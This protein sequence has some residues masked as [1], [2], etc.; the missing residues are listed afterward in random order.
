MQEDKIVKRIPTNLV[1]KTII[2]SSAEYESNREYTDEDANIYEKY[3]QA[4]TNVSIDINGDIEKIKA[5]EETV[6]KNEEER[7]K[8]EQERIEKEK[9]RI[10]NES[11]RIINEN[12]RIE[13]ENNRSNAEETRQANESER[14]ANESARKLAEESREKITTEAVNNIKDLSESYNALAEEKETELNNIAEDVKDMATEFDKNATEQTNTFNSNAE[15]KTSD[16]NTNA[17]TKHTEYDNNAT[18]KLEEYNA[19]VNEF[20]EKAENY[21]K[22]IED[23]EQEVSELSDNNLWA[24]T[25]QATELTVD[26]VAKYSK[27]KLSLFGNTYQDKTKMTYKCNG[28][29]S[30]D[31]YFSYNSVNYKFTMPDIV[32]DDIMIFDTTT[33]AFTVNDTEITTEVVDDVTELTQITLNSAPNPDYPQPIQVV[34]GENTI[35][36]QGKNLFNKDKGIIKN[37]QIDYTN[38]NIKYSKGDFYQEDYIT[39]KPNTKYTISSVSKSW[40]RVIE[41]DSNKNYI[42]GNGFHASVITTTNTTKYVRIT[43]ST[44]YIDTLQ[45]EEGSSATEYIAYYN[46][47]YK[48]NL[49][50]IELC[51][52]G[53]NQDFIF[54]NEKNSQHYDSKLIENAWYKYVT[55]YKYVINGDEEITTYEAHGKPIFGIQVDKAFSI[56]I[57][58]LYRSSRTNKNENLVIM[59]SWQNRIQIRDDRF[60]EDG[61]GNVEAFRE[62]LIKNNLIVYGVLSNNFY[63][64]ITDETLISQLEELQ[65]IALQKG[66]III[67]SS[68]EDGLAVNMQLTYMQDLQSKLNQLESMIISNASEEVTQ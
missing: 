42:K 10:K 1:T 30:G 4:I 2:T 50:N 21:E 62:E 46:K 68:S 37:Y 51:V 13:A 15:N 12:S 41:Y 61:T 49:G 55:I 22:R 32:E 66:K 35:E 16:F 24:T 47:K 59:E 44:A 63:E 19:K 54:K 29:E 31:Y 27:N 23:L 28:S 20:N 14:I 56:T 38:G 43:T 53:T 11:D 57:S 67:T 17:S 5:L 6:T 18:S 45:F 48:L 52:I 58:N 26:D 8:A 25:E 39:V 40:M 7:K 36:I 65:K 64:K 34:T 3:L 60:V 33:L 9:T